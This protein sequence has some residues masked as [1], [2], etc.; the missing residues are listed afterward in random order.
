MAALAVLALGLAG[1]TGARAADPATTAWAAGASNMGEC[2][3]FLGTQGLRDDVNAM[4]RERGDVLGIANPGQIFHLRARQPVS[5]PPAQECL[6][7]R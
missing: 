2:S 1:T 5:L 3:A 7:R 6:P 4:I